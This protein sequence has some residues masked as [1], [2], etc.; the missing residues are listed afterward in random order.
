MYRSIKKCI[1]GWQIFAFG[2][3]P[4]MVGTDVGCW[5]QGRAGLAACLETEE[6]VTET[7]SRCASQGSPVLL[8]LTRDLTCDCD[9]WAVSWSD[10]QELAAVFPLSQ[11]FYGRLRD[12]LQ[13]PVQPRRHRQRQSPRQQPGAGRCGVPHIF[14]ELT[15]VSSLIAACELVNLF[16]KL[17]CPLV[18]TIH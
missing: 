2:Q 17:V 4:V 6:L 11:S 1:K 12:G 8:R 7:Q 5:W 16:V 13:I 3:K 10:H 14:Q 15:Q 18:W 9:L